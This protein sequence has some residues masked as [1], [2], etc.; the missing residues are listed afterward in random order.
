MKLHQ[1]F[2]ASVVCCLAIGFSL[3]DAYAQDPTGQQHTEMIQRQ[4]SAA[5][6]RANQTG[7]TTT[8]SSTYSYR[9]KTGHAADRAYRRDQKALER[10]DED[11][12]IYG[13]EYPGGYRKAPDGTMYNPDG[14]VAVAS[15][16]TEKERA[17][18]L[19]K[20]KKLKKKHMRQDRRAGRRP[21]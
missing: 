2:T 8:P 15:S 9:G 11:N 17:K 1:V 16:E 20:T 3:P 5:Q 13:T 4:S 18:R 21:N 12:V 6:Q 7:A 10:H 19:K 14:T